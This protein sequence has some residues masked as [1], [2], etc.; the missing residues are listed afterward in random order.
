MVIK[1]KSSNSMKYLLTRWYERVVETQNQYLSNLNFIIKKSEEQILSNLLELEKF[2]G[3]AVNKEVL[4]IK[5]K[6]TNS[7]YFL[8]PYL[9]ELIE[10]IHNFMTLLEEI[11]GFNLDISTRTNLMNIL[12]IELETHE[13]LNLT[14]KNL[15][16]SINAV[17]SS[18]RKSD[19]NNE[20]AFDNYFKE[21]SRI[22]RTVSRDFDNL[23][24]FFSTSK[25]KL[26]L[27]VNIAMEQ[28]EEQI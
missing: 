26:K 12:K 1:F 24:E 23:T 17:F 5:E 10:Y 20:V 16:K 11:D 13:K 3:K 15:I 2:L 7:S 18:E 6:I 22:V 14:L 19:K 9:L 27:E 28:S 8:E 21:F 25:E 4:Q